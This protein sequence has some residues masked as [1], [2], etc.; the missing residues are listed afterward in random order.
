MARTTMCKHHQAQRIRISLIFCWRRRPL[1]K[2]VNTLLVNL[3]Q[4]FNWYFSQ[5]AS[6]LSLNS[7]LYSVK[8]L[9]E[10]NYD[11]TPSVEVV[12]FRHSDSDTINELWSFLICCFRCTHLCYLY[13]KF[14][15]LNNP[16]YFP[17]WIEFKFLHSI[18]HH[19]L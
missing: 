19:F 10:I 11:F 2:Y 12:I 9:P 7:L 1:I 17:K 16:I 8:S 6:V 13:P 3:N 4:S 15:S 18:N 14:I 5:T